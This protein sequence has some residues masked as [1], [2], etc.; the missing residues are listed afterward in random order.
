MSSPRPLQ[1]AAFTLEGTEASLPG[2]RV[3]GLYW[4]GWECPRFEVAQV[5]AVI[6]L[7]AECGIHAR[8]LDAAR[9]DAGI[10]VTDDEWPDQP[11]TLYPTRALLGAEGR[12]AMVYDFS[13][14]L[15]WWPADR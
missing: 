9:P 2:W 14:A 4:N 15:C 13:L 3:R 6:A 11:S 8:L 5:G 12:E 10:L 1:P 7:L